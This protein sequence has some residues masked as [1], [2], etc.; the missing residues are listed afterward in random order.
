MPSALTIVEYG[1]ISQYLSADAIAKGTVFSNGNL[2]PMLPEQLNIVWTSLE[3]LIDTDPTNDGI[4]ET[5]NFLF[6]LCGKW[7]LAASATVGN[8]GGQV[9]EPPSGLGSVIVAIYLQ[10]TV[11]DVGAA[12]LAGETVLTI[13]Y[14]DILLNSISITKDS[15]PLPI[16][17]NNQQSFTVV[18]SASNAVITFNEAVSDDQLFVVR[19]L[20]YINI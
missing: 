2:N 18:Y 15:V 17:L 4:T 1:K 7:A 8:S 11:G 13:T 12:M 10:F 9:I 3:H 16:G 5:K 19:G 6:S 14:D 20:R